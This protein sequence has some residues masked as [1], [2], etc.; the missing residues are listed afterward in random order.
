MADEAYLAVARAH[1]DLYTRYAF[2]LLAVVG[3]A[4]GFA[5]NQTQ[6]AVLAWSQVPLGLAISSW[7]LS[8][9]FG[10]RQL[11]SVK[12][13]LFANSLLLAVE[14][15]HHPELPN[16]PE[17]R[18]IIREKVEQSG[19]HAGRFSVLQV[20]ALLIGVFFYVSWHVLEMYLR[21]HSSS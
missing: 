15:G 16:S 5:L 11:K 21:Q 3:A 13:T 14:D 4:V 20:R 12:A 9:Y 8:F 19:K 17:T 1:R 2:Y 18:A 10:L 6:G 7:F